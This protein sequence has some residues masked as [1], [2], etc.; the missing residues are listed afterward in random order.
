MKD[1]IYIP[2]ADEIQQAF[3]ES[4]AL[5]VTIGDQ[6]LILHVDWT[7]VETRVLSLWKGL[8]ESMA[9]AVRAGVRQGLEADWLEYGPGQYVPRLPLEAHLADDDQIKTMVEF[10]KAGKQKEFRQL[11]IMLGINQKHLDALWEGTV[12]RVGGQA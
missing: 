6:E 12:K 10:A 8:D 4:G 5:R 2:S 7:L 9:N 3:H 1:A 11:A